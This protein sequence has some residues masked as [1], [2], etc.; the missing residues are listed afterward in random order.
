VTRLVQPSREHLPLYVAALE[1]G[2]SADNTRGGAPRLEEL[3]RIAADVDTYLAEQH[4]PQGL[5][6]PVTLPDG[7]T[8]PRLPGFRCWI[9]DDTTAGDADSGAAQGS[10]CG[11]FCGLI[12]LRWQPGTPALPPYVLGHIGYVLVPHQRGRGHAK[13]ALAQMLP[14]ARAQG[15]PWVDL[16]TD[17]DNTASQRVITANGGVLVERFVRDA[18]QGGTPALRFRIA[19]A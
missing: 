16:T 13:R 7:S 9:L 18:A 6:P 12:G 10:P 11:P 5:G 17:P 14:L 15:L 4:D 1:S 3:A 19:L 8:R 2:W